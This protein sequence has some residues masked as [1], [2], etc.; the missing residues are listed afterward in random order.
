MS[1][2]KRLYKLKKSDCQASPDKYTWIVGQGCFEKTKSPVKSVRKSPVKSVRKS[3]IKMD[4]KKYFKTTDNEK[5]CKGD[6][7]R[8]VPG[9]CETTEN[10]LDKF[11][12]KKDEWE[13]PICFIYNKSS[14]LRCYICDTVKPG[15][16]YSP[17]SKIKVQLS[18]KKIS[19]KQVSAKKSSPKKGSPK[20]SPQKGSPKREV[21]PGFDLKEAVFSVL[22]NYSNNIKW[23]VKKLKEQI[24][25]DYY[26]PLTYLDD[27]KESLKSYYT[28]FMTREDFMYKLH[29]KFISFYKEKGVKVTPEIEKDIHYK[30]LAS[31]EEKVKEL[32]F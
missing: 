32:T 4:S 31:W 21:L 19:P 11:K 25:E 2:G 10:P 1:K 22:D 5:S 17:P 9:Y 8:W 29:K 6:T 7:K 14:D 13:C 24:V 12:M 3:P 16:T 30:S 15:L 23:T 26:L 18:P 20:K 27:K 28:E